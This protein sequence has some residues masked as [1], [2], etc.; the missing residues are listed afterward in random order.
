[1]SINCSVSDL[2]L[3]AQLIASTQ[4]PSIIQLS[5]FPGTACQLANPRY[6]FKPFKV[7]RFIFRNSTH[8]C[9]M[10][11]DDN[12]NKQE[13]CKQKVKEYK[14][15][16]FV[17]GNMPK[18]VSSKSS[19]LDRCGGLTFLANLCSTRSLSSSFTLFNC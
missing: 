5:Q 1:M 16:S 15:R 3:P 6:L 7:S 19:H 18:T 10:L 8:S 13:V 2:T 14:S 12:E 17:W 11:N 9:S 4:F